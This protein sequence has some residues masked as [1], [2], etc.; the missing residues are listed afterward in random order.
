M[1]GFDFGANQGQ[2]D[3]RLMGMEFILSLESDPGIQEI[4]KQHSLIS[5]AMG[6]I[7]IPAAGAV[8][9]L[10]NI[11]SMYYRINNAVGV[12]FSKNITKSVAGMIASHLAQRALIVAGLEALKFMPFLGTLVGGAGEAVVLGA[13]TAVQGKLY[14]EWLRYMCIK[15]AVHAD[16]TIDETV[17]AS[18]IDKIFANKGRI[19][20]MVQEAKEYAKNLDFKKYIA[21]AQE[22]VAKYKNGNVK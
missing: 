2:R 10:G 11:Y 22:L 1:A 14:C 8:A 17:S 3:A 5:G 7:P 6:L 9:S 15:K 20:A 12:S 4:M 16:G 13:S 21:Q 19:E 18:V